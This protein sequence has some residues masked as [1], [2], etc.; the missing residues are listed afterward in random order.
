LRCFRFFATGTQVGNQIVDFGWFEIVGKWRHLFSAVK[1]LLAYLG[2]RQ[3]AAHT[4]KIRPLVA[5]LVLNGMAVP[6]SGSGE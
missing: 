6:A 1:N 4:G 2:L 3:E 5:T